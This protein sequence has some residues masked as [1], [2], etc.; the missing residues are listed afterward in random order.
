MS[1]PTYQDPK[2]TLSRIYTRGGDKGQTSLVNGRR[3]A[4]DDPKVEA[5]GAVDELNAGRRSARHGNRPAQRS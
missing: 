3:V 2:I 4:K 1:E 5:Y